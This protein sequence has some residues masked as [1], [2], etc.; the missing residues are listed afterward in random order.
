MVRTGK[1]LLYKTILKVV[2]ETIEDVLKEEITFTIAEKL[3][4]KYSVSE[5]KNLTQQYHACVT[6]GV[7]AVDT[8][9]ISISFNMGWQKKGTGHTYDSNS[10]LTILEFDVVD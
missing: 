4:G 8:M 9:H 1:I 10:M 6:T 3:E 7:E 5:I 2:D